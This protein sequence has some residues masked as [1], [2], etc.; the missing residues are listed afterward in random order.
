[1]ILGKAKS[2]V[3]KYQKILGLQDWTVEVTLSSALELE[4]GTVAN[5]VPNY[6]H[7]LAKIKIIQDKYFDK[8]HE[9]EETVIHELL[10]IYFNIDPAMD[11]FQRIR[12]E[13]GLN[14]LAKLIRVAYAKR[15]RITS[16]TKRS[17]R[18]NK[19]RRN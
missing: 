9:L 11:E 12:I 10:H 16:R 5:I 17:A 18:S 4:N 3:K 6:E 15:Q 7:R 13:Q 1:M 14:Q 19:P 8:E 2:F